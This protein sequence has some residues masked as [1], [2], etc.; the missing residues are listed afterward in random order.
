MTASSTTRNMY[1]L[2]TIIILAQWE[3]HTRSWCYYIIDE[4]VDLQAQMWAMPNT[5]M[6]DWHWSN[7]SRYLVILHVQRAAINSAT[8]I[9]LP[10]VAPVTLVGQPVSHC[11]VVI[12][13]IHCWKLRLLWADLTTIMTKSD[14]LTDHLYNNMYMYAVTKGTNSQYHI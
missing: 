6:S 9:N 8:L 11:E 1:P 3:N 12:N 4:Y 14:C 7:R 13:E 2:V 10:K 5:C